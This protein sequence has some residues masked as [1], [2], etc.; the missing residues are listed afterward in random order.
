M[1]NKEVG[2]PSGFKAEEA[3]A[4]GSTSK[5]AICMRGIRMLDIAKDFQS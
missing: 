4:R 1:G 5:G 2:Q 3:D